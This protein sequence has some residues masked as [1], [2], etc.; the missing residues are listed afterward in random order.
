MAIEHGMEGA[1]GGEFDIGEAAQQPLADF[2]S[3]PAGML[4]LH[5]QDVVLHLERKLVGV[6]IG[7]TAAIGESLHPALLIAIEDL[8]AG[9]ARNSELPAQ[10]RHRFAR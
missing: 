8:V 4:M 2:S 6:T 9:L 5:I 7:T 10:I 1:F 3:P